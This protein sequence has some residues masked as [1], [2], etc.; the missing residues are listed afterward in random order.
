M[1]TIAAL[2]P[3]EVEEIALSYGFATENYFPHAPDH[4]E[5]EGR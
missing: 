1:T 2:C 3:G 4:S 5:N